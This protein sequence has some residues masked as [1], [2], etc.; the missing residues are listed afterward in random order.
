MAAD[1]HFDCQPE[2]VNWDDGQ[3][4]GAR[5]APD[6]KYAV[7]LPIHQMTDLTS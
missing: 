2:Q 5:M 1:D 3:L 4:P 7:P 6:Q